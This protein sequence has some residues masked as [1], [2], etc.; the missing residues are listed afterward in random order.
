MKEN[1]GIGIQGGGEAASTEK[2][3]SGSIVE[4]IEKLNVLTLRYC[5]KFIKLFSTTKKF[6]SMIFWRFKKKFT[7]FSRF[8]RQSI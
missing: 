5:K 3:C 4:N 1:N 2:N 7:G 8:S 6:K